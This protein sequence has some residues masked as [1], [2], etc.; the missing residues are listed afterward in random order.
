MRRREGG[1]PLRDVMKAR[2][3]GLEQVAALTKEIDGQGV[4]F[5]LVAFMATRKAYARESLS[6]R[7]A[8]LIEK[9]LDVPPGTFFE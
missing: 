5:Q 7:S 1:Q 3:L 4:S 8:M 6:E 9:A 2:K